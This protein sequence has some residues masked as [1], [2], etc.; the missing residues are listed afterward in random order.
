MIAR[1]TSQTLPEG[2]R[3]NRARRWFRGWRSGL[4]TVVDAVVVTSRKLV[5]KFNASTARGRAYLASGV[6][7]DVRSPLLAWL[8]V[9]AVVLGA[10]VGIAIASPGTDRRAAA[11][12]GAASLMWMAIRW[13]GMRWAAPKLTAED[14]DAL[15]GA[16][17]LGLL[18]YALAVTPEL[19]LA[20]W[21]A[22]G[23]ITS[24]VLV[25]IGRDRREVARAVGY[26]WG[27]QALVVAGGWLARNAYFAFVATRG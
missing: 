8:G 17:A 14:G 25:R 22:A 12:A 18:A 9:V 26:A 4:T 6:L 19:R 2:K 15:R 20:A 13:L 3:D 21:L 7:T 27:I 1:G 10:T 23:A 24:V 11:L 5:R 16:Y